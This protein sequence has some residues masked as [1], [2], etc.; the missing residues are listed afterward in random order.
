[1]ISLRNLLRAPARSLMTAGGVAAGIGLFVAILAITTDLH[2]QIGAVADAYTLEVVVYERR[3]NSPLSSRIP[4]GQMQALQ[5]RFGDTVSPFVIGTLNERWNSYALV[6]GAP[7]EF[8]HRTQLIE[9]RAAQAESDEVVL[10]EVAAQRL[11]LTPG[12]TIALDGRERPI[13]GIYRTGSRMLD[14]GVMTGIAQA[15]RMLGREGVEAQ[16]TLAL[17]RARDRAG[18]AELMRK[19]E[20]AEPTLRAIPGT[21]FAGA[22]RLLRV[23]NAF[24]TT[25]SVVALVG[26]VLVV[27]NTMMMAIA[28]RTR[29]IGILMTVGWSPWRVLRMFAAESILV[30]LAGTAL[31]HGFALLLLRAVNR[32]ESVG[33]GW[34]PVRYSWS[35]AAASIA[36]AAG[37]GVIALAWPAVVVTRMQPLAALRRE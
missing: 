5:R 35:V 3:A 32:M 24:V 9:G 21:E 14:G 1:L 6:I 12:A 25:I 11:R 36:V 18:A 19:V 17:L 7:R 20:A 34:I 31:G 30:C 22:L 13:V 27:S 26:T 23:V 15:Q 37:V 29:E 33:F 16:Y 28:E 4:V 2:E 10:G 8:A